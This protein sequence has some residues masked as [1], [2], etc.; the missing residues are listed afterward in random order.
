MYVHM[1]SELVKFCLTA[2]IKMFDVELMDVM[3]GTA[4]ERK[5][6]ISSSVFSIVCCIPVSSVV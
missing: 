1:K 4:S 6:E 5:G 2:E 3:G